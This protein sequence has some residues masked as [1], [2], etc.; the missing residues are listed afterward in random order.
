MGIMMMKVKECSLSI[1]GVNKMTNLNLRVWHIPQVPMD[2]PFYVTVK[3]PEEAI[4]MLNLLWSYDDYQ[5][6]NKI[7]L[8]SKS[9]DKITKIFSEHL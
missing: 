7:K 4:K 5:F 2:D 9:R 1:E 3:S 8:I 6:R